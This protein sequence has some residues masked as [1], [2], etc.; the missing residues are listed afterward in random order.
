MLGTIEAGLKNRNIVFEMPIVPE[1]NA[2][3]EEQKAFIDS[4]LNKAPIA[5][6]A[7]EAAEALRIADLINVMVNSKKV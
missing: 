5:V 6:S 4:V 2:I 7:A 1:I 3:A